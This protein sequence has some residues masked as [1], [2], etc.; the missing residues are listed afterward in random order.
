MRSMNYW[1]NWVR[2]DTGI[3]DKGT[4]DVQFHPYLL[5]KHLHMVNKPFIDS[6]TLHFI[7]YT[8]G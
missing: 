8:C 5:C 2:T 7:F 6:V 4:L 1:V 3:W